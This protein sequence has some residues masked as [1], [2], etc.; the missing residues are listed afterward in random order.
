[1]LSFRPKL[2]HTPYEYIKTENGQV[3]F[4]AKYSYCCWITSKTIYNEEQD[5]TYYPGE[6]CFA[7]QGYFDE[8]GVYSEINELKN[9]SEVY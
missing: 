2:Y 7:V 8:N 4:C 1:M 6:V 9:F 5:H 3:L